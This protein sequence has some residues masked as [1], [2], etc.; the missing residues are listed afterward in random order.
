MS[1]TVANPNRVRNLSHEDF[2]IDAEQAAAQAEAAS[3]QIA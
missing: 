1:T 2:A 3:E